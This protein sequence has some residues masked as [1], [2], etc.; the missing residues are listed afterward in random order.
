[1]HP[2]LDVPSAP[3]RSSTD[4]SV[5]PRSRTD[6]LSDAVLAPG[7]PEASQDSGSGAPSVCSTSYLGILKPGH[8]NAAVVAEGDPCV[9]CIAGCRGRRVWNRTAASV[10]ETLARFGSRK[11]PGQ[12]CA[13]TQELTA[14]LPDNGHSLS[15]LGVTP[16]RAPER[17]TQ[18]P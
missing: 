15:H 5:M 3:P 14:T 11:A 6:A 9:A 17:R 4:S 7:S 10:H 18:A 12:A 2:P 1:M 13:V 16:L 8:G